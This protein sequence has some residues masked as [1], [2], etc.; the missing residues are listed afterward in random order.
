MI[1]LYRASVD[2]RSFAFEAFAETDQGA[3]FAL[4]EGL[5]KHARQYRLVVGDFIRA[6]EDDITVRPIVIGCAYRDR[7]PLR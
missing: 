4:N 1:T 7:E 6:V 5:E 3:I 2:T